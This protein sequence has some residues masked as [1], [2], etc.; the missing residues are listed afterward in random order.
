MYQQTML[1]IELIFT[2]DEPIEFD[3]YHTLGSALDI[4]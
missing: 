4:V 2:C 1:E 3:S